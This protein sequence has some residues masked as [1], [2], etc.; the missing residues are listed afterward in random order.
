MEGSSPYTASNVSDAGFYGR[1]SKTPAW[2]TDLYSLGSNENCAK[3][4]TFREYI[5]I[6]DDL[7]LKCASR[8]P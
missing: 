1:V 6:V 2:R 3:P 8:S 5:Q 7:G 4:F